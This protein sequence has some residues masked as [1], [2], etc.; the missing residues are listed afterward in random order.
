MKFVPAR[1]IR[2]QSLHH[3]RASENPRFAPRE[4]CDP[5]TQEIVS[6]QLA[7]PGPLLAAECFP[8]HPFDSVENL[9]TLRKLGLQTKVR[10]DFLLRTALSL[11]TL[12][13]RPE[14]DPELLPK[15][16]SCSKA[17]LNYISVNLKSLKKE[18]EHMLLRRLREVPWIA[19]QCGPHFNAK[20]SQDQPP[21]LWRATH[22]D[23]DDD[24]E[25][26]S[27]AHKLL[28]MPI[29]GPCLCDSKKNAHSAFCSLNARTQL[30]HS[31]KTAPSSESAGVSSSSNCADTADGSGAE[32]TVEKKAIARNAC[33]H[34]HHHYPPVIFVAPDSIRPRVLET[35]CSSTFYI[36]N[37]VVGKTAPSPRTG[38]SRGVHVAPSPFQMRRLH[39]FFGWDRDPSKIS[40]Q[41]I[42]YQICSIAFRYHALLQQTGSMDEGVQFRHFSSF[43]TDYLLTRG[44]ISASSIHEF[45][46]S[47]LE[48]LLLPLYEFLWN[49]VS[50]THSTNADTAE[51]GVALAADSQLSATPTELDDKE[52]LS[53]PPPK[54]SE[55]LPSVHHAKTTAVFETGLLSEPWVWC[56]AHVGFKNISS[57]AFDVDTRLEP[58]LCGIPSSLSKFESVC[59]FFVV[60]V[61]V[62]DHLESL[63]PRSAPL[64]LYYN[65]FCFL[66][67]RGGV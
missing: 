3:D 42:Q 62:A 45:A 20:S 44:E 15:L 27:V 50:S 49:A 56:G 37:G 32:T 6:L 13:S 53:P 39:S 67:G 34:H 26:S 30:L 59:M 19:L 4:L 33:D 35:W 54:K 43:S 5:S 16:V 14:S 28:Y 2:G 12:S 1:Q 29:S 22:D 8:A 10:L 57:V 58:Y 51:E 23:D 52:V 61:T 66:G 63:Q 48:D 65:F 64:L 47:R 21:F 11:A 25:A 40:I 60:S 18:D 7:R 55:P 41:T 24:D 9:A 17:V 46:D 38:S 36:V 31:D